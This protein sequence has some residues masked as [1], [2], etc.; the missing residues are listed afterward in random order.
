[1]AAQFLQWWDDVVEEYGDPRVADWPLMDSPR[2][3]TIMVIIYLFIVWIGPK[4]MK[5]REPFSLKHVIAVY[6]FSMVVLSWYLLWE[7]LMGGWG[8]GYSYGC[9]VV[10]YSDS[11]QAL[12]MANCCWWFYFSKFIE[13]LDTVF[14]ILRKKNRQIS[15]LHVFHHALMPFSW[16]IGVKFVAGGFGTFHAMLNSWIHFMMYIYYGLS[17]LGPEWQKY[18][19][20]KK[21]MTTMQLTQFFLVMVHCGQL[22]F[23][24]CSYPKVFVWIIGSYGFIFFWMFL[25]FYIQSYSKGAKAKSGTTTTKSENGV[26]NGVD[27]GHH[28]KSH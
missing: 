26:T 5:N 4:L 15:F 13:M 17:G 23:I 24:E 7:F 27:G 6:N 25:H 11:P 1:M 20:W 2:T 21:Y 28:V 16:W 18:L 9:Q 14:F 8:T 3:G 22:L 12:R 19:W 10:D